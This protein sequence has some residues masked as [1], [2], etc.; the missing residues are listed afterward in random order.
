MT[1][2]LSLVE[3]EFRG[4]INIEDSKNIKQNVKVFFPTCE[5]KL[6]GWKEETR[7]DD[8]V[9]IVVDIPSEAAKDR[10]IK[11]LEELSRKFSGDACL[12]VEKYV[13]FAHH[14]NRGINGYSWT[15]PAVI[16]ILA[17]I[18]EIKN[19]IF[20]VS[21]TLNEN[22]TPDSIDCCLN[23]LDCNILHYLNN[24]CKWTRKTCHVLLF[25]CSNEVKELDSKVNKCKEE[26]KNYYWDSFNLSNLKLDFNQVDSTD[27]LI[28]KFEQIFE[29]KQN[30]IAKFFDPFVKWK[31]NHSV[32]LT[33]VVS[34]I[35][36]SN[37]SLNIDFVELEVLEERKTE[38]SLEKNEKRGEN[39]KSRNIEELNI[40][41]RPIEVGEF[42]EFVKEE[43]K[44]ENGDGFTVP[45]YGPGGSG[46]T[47][48]L[49]WL[50]NRL[51]DEYKG[52]LPVYVE[53]KDLDTPWK[54]KGVKGYFKEVPPLLII[55]D[56]LDEASETLEKLQERIKQQLN[57][58]FKIKGWIYSTREDVIRSG[59]QNGIV[60]FRT[61]AIKE[62]RVRK[63]IETYVGALLSSSSEQERESKVNEIYNYYKK[64]ISSS[65]GF[66]EVLRIPFYLAIFVYLSLQNKIE[67]IQD[68]H[69]LVV[70]FI[71][72]L[73]EENFGRIRNRTDIKKSDYII[74]TLAILSL[75]AFLMLR[76]KLYRKEENYII[77]SGVKNVDL[78]LDF[79]KDGENIGGVEVLYG[80]S[81]V[82]P[83]DFNNDKGA[84]LDVL[85]NLCRKRGITG[86][87][88]SVYLLSLSL[89]CDLLGLNGIPDDRLH[90]LSSLL[91]NVLSREA[92]EKSGILTVNRVSKAEGFLG[93][94]EY[95]FSFIH[96]IVHENLIS[97]F[98][99][100]V[101]AYLKDKEEF[102]FNS[103]KFSWKNPL[104]L[105]GM[106]EDTGIPGH[107]SPFDYLSVSVLWMKE[108][109][110]LETEE[111]VQEKIYEFAYNLLAIL[112]EVKA[113]NDEF[114]NII[115]D[116]VIFNY[117]EL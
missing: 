64:L 32:D 88:L 107:I 42:L 43:L 60:G 63:F 9:D 38:V 19:T 83:W 99:A 78:F 47:F 89:I 46:K 2:E 114:F 23:K 30:K 26:G 87:E 98:I 58:E 81:V 69:H 52:A 59:G 104:K 93:S 96:R 71:T 57:T 36:S 11:L 116:S 94:D 113:E 27:G 44:K 67:N 110:N 49:K 3:I 79:S 73:L 48:L 65:D 82:T 22:G 74:S 15:I 21:G 45:V 40:I 51:L 56:G 92:L 61:G 106:L 53:A 20:L 18:T 54:I 75:M 90:N 91:R 109:A 6:F 10:I 13:R 31:E 72:K 97:A 112:D 35:E 117:L 39:L 84:A 70:R 28:V 68:S 76:L 4:P 24:I 25:N 102:E 100:I 111:K 55:L 5:G 103:K 101:A 1:K 50:H 14:G 95:R 41:S 80:D 7:E 37:K 85:E 16:A 86:R 12:N 17:A 115:R 105:I 33:P 34:G 108:I 29:E 8:G 66:S 62:E 77:A